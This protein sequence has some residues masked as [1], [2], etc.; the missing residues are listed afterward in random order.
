ML[1]WRPSKLTYRSLIWLMIGLGMLAYPVSAA[2]QQPEAVP[3]AGAGW[4]LLYVEADWCTACNKVTPLVD[5]LAE[6]YEGAVRVVRVDVDQT[7]EIRSQVGL[8]GVPTLMLFK[9]GQRVEHM[10]GAL[11]TADMKAQI[12]PYLTE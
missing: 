1:T 7:P 8:V 3:F 12:L 5:D 10:P 11:P 9:D 2:R 4:V 6:N